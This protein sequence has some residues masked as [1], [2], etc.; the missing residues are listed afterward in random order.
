MRKN[1]LLIGLGRFGRYTAMKLKELNQQV[2][3]VD[4]NEEQVEKVLPYVTYGQIGD[5]TNEEFLRTLGVPDYDVCIV[6]IGDSFIA[7]LET[8]S[9]LKELGA[10]KVISRATGKSQEKFLLRNGA[11]EVIFPEKQ[12]AVWTAIRCSSSLISNYIDLSSG[13]AIYEVDVPDE[14]V[15]QSILS[16]G[17][18][19]RFGLNVLGIRRDGEMVINASPDTV[20]KKTDHVLVL[21]KDEDVRKHLHLR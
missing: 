15:S 21:G 11:D 14:W 10:K 17:I 3:A 13:Y 16:L 12:L 8:T 2:M 20:L 4:R 19:R 18:R 1:I 5:G 7:S 9:L 6:A